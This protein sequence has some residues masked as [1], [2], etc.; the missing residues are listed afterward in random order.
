MRLRC[1]YCGKSVSSELAAGTIIRAAAQCPECVE[2]ETTRELTLGDGRKVQLVRRLLKGSRTVTISDLESLA[3][4]LDSDD[5]LAALGV[6]AATVVLTR[7][8][9][10]IT[11]FA[12]RHRVTQIVAWLNVD[13]ELIELA[14]EQMSREL[15]AVAPPRTE[16][17]DATG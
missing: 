15:A 1:F 12:G 11:M 4:R 2:A 13:F 3:K 14:V 10:Q 8:G 9:L 7:R 6:D 16:G 5:G 17:S